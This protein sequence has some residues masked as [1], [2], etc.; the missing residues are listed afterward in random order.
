MSQLERRLIKVSKAKQKR[1]LGTARMLFST[2]LKPFYS[3]YVL[4]AVTSMVAVVVWFELTALAV[5]VSSK[6]KAHE[7]AAG[8]ANPEGSGDAILM[9]AAVV[10][11]KASW[12]V[13]P[14]MYLTVTVYVE[15][16]R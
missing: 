11:I 13:G 15:I 3:P 16:G 6:S 2:S 4:S 10:P 14:V 8:N 1:K 12:P 9:V 5:V 7:P